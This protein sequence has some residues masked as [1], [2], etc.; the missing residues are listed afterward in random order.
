MATKI[1]S[2]VLTVPEDHIGDRVDVF[3]AAQLGISRSRI[4][5]SIEAGDVLVNGKV[6]R[7]SHRL[8]AADTIDADIPEAVATDLIP[9]DLPLTILYEDDAILVLEKAAGMVV[10]PAAGITQGTLANALAFHLKME[11]EAAGRQLS[12][13]GSYRPGLVHRLDR[14]T[15]GVMVVAKTEAALEHLANQFR[16]RTV[17]KH[18]TALVYGQVNGNKITVDAPLARDRNNRLKMTV[19]R[20]GEGR[21][22]LSIVKVTRRFQEFTLLDVEIKTGRTHQ[23]RVHCAHLKH[24]VVA[25]DVYGKGRSANLQKHTHRIAVEQLGRQFLHAATLGFTH[26]VTGERMYFRSALPAE[27]THL[28]SLLEEEDTAHERLH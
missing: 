21:N 10:H 20:P 6:V 2:E 19:C 1:E 27:L 11:H 15:S 22:A 5:R 25:D 12:T 7:V 23:I 16:D 26:P 4:Q 24:P 28:L 14:D 3:L 13:D 17:E 9:E 18:Y 8:R